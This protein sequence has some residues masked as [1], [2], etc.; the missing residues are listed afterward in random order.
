LS[1]AWGSEPLLLLIKKDRGF[2]I[3]VAFCRRIVM[4]TGNKRL[5]MIRPKLECSAF[6]YKGNVTTYPSSDK[7]CFLTKGVSGPHSHPGLGHDPRRTGRHCGL[8]A[9]GLRVLN[10]EVGLYGINPVAYGR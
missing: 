2:L 6:K 1:F 10:S 3:H 4:L 5:K 9:A 8:Q 7:A